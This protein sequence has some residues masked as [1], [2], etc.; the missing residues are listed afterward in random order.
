MTTFLYQIDDCELQ[1]TMKERKF[2]IKSQFLGKIIILSKL[3][4]LMGDNIET[5]R[6]TSSEN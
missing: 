5:G 1:M 4:L 6:C 3:G 2:W